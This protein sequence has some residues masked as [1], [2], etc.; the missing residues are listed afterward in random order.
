MLIKAINKIAAFCLLPI[1]LLCRFNAKAQPLPNEEMLN[2]NRFFNEIGNKEKLQPLFQKLVNCNEQSCMISVLHL[3]D[4]HVKSKYYSRSLEA[5]LNAMFNQQEHLYKLNDTTVAR[6]TYFFNLQEYAFVGTRFQNYYRSA[7]F[8][9]Y[10]AANQPDLLIVSL[11]TNDAY[12]GV[13]ISVMNTQMQELIDLVKKASPNSV[14]LFTTPPDELKPINTR[15]GGSRLEQ[16]RQAIIQNCIADT[17]P[18]WNLYY[19]MGGMG[20]MRAW[21]RWGFATADDVHYTGN[22][23]TI[24]GRLLAESIFGYYQK[25]IP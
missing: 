24:F 21:K 8:E 19:V 25:L 7:P 14:L 17:I 11:G 2:I 9:K 12:S 5:A 4:S 16:V 3:G 1:L 18:Y 20:T 10:L 13:S 22:G 15:D 6:K 23:Y